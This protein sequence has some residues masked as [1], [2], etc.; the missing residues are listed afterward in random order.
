MS[1]EFTVISIGTM[2]RNLLWGETAAVRTSH[3]TTTLV[4]A[5]KRLILVDPSLPATVL[6]ARFSERTGKTFGDV[7]D[8]FCTTLRPV[9]RRGIAALHHAQWWVHED[10]LDAYRRH[11]EGLKDTAERISEED[12]GAVDAD[13]KLLEQFRPAP[14]EFDEQVTVYPMAGPSPGSAG[15][16]LTPATASIVIAG[17]GAVTGEHVRRGQIWEGCA[18]REAAL[19]T[20][21]DCMELADTI[22]CGH[23]NVMHLAGKW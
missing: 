15:L 23:D 18:D 3:A 21:Q 4:T 12:A 6:A 7:T 19:R 10:E 13:L 2:S 8:V 5:G 9:H 22:V 16:L 11:L 17:D 20:L 1:V 14:E